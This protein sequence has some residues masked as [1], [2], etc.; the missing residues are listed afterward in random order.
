[1]LVEC[2]FSESEVKCLKE[3]ED[4]LN[5]MGYFFSDKDIICDLP[6]KFYK[7]SGYKTVISEII[8]NL[9]NKIREIDSNFFVS[10]GLSLV[11]IKTNQVSLEVENMSLP[12]RK[13]KYYFNFGQQKGE[14][15]INGKESFYGNFC[16]SLIYSEANRFL[17]SFMNIPSVEPMIYET[18]ALYYY[19]RKKQCYEVSVM[20]AIWS[21]HNNN[22]YP[23]MLGMIIREEYLR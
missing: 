23:K 16:A 4:K 21:Y 12:N 9:C 11:K 2:N 19:D 6:I 18:Y 3:Y 13:A 17:K 22:C 8:F 5:N 14:Y 20:P 10:Y 7:Y 15:T 1:M